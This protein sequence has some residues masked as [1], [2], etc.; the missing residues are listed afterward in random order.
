MALRICMMSLFPVAIITLFWQYQIGMSMQDIMLL[1]AAFSLTIVLLEFPA[2]YIGD[3]IGYKKSLLIGFTTCTLGWSIYLLGSEFSHLLIAEIILAAGLCFISG[4]DLALLYDTLKAENKETEYSLWNSRYVAYGQIGEGL[5]ALS[6]GII[7]VYWARLPFY[8]EVAVFLLGS[9]LCLLLK[10]IEKK[11]S[12]TQST[13]AAATSA[14]EAAK[15]INPSNSQ[16]T[17]PNQADEPLN[18]HLNNFKHILAASF[19]HSPLLRWSL[20]LSCFFGLASYFPVWIIQLHATDAGVSTAW[21]GLV[22]SLANFMVAIGA[23]IG[24]RIEKSFGLI[25]IMGLCLVLMSTGYL[26]LTLNQNIWGF[27]FYFLITLARGI[28]GPLLTNQIQLQIKSQFRAATLSLRSLLIRAGFMLTA[29]FLGLYID[30]QGSHA[31]F[32]VLGIGFSASLST[33]LFFLWK[34]QL[35]KNQPHLR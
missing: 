35:P 19:I 24:P 29:P 4:S 32:A 16:S 18:Q 21:L 25:L 9:A 6:A 5:A 34:N 11:P 14:P 2:G 22:W 26:G 12:D 3:Q 20:I 10:E 7:Y 27:G 1:Q 31:A 15:N 28:N 13:T 8:L 33:A 30:A 17:R 23:F